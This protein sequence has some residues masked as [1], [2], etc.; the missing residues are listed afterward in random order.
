[1][2][3]SPDAPVFQIYA[4]AANAAFVDK[5][6][7]AL[8]LAGC[9]V[10]NGPFDPE[11][12][13]AVIVVWSGAAINSP[14]LIAAAEAP[15][16]AGALAPVS[17]G[18]IEPPEPFQAIPAVNLGGWTGDPDDPR[19]RRALEAARQVAARRRGLGP[20]PG[21]AA[22]VSVPHTDNSGALGEKLRRARAGA[23]R[24]AR[25]AGRAAAAAGGLAGRALA[26]GAGL[27]AGGLSRAFRALSGAR[28]PIA[29]GFAAARGRL[30]ALSGGTFGRLRGVSLD[31]LLRLLTSRPALTATG[32]A[33]FAIVA[34]GLLLAP[35]GAPDPG[36]RADAPRA[37]RPAPAPSTAP[38]ESGPPTLAHLQ[39]LD[40][41][42]AD[43]APKEAP[44]AEGD[45]DPDAPAPGETPDRL[46]ALIADA[47][48]AAAQ[49]EAPA[50]PEDAAPE[51]AEPEPP[52]AAAS[53]EAFRD[54][55]VC[56]LMRVAPAG[57]FR[58]GSPPNEPARQASEGP[59]IDVAIARPFAIGVHEITF[60]QW[61]ACVAD[62]GCDRH[63][64]GD[65]GWGR[66]ERPV[67]NV[68]WDDAQ[69]YVRWLSEKTG[70]AYRLPSEAEWEY[71][72]RAGATTPF[73]TG[74][75][76]T[77][78]QANFNGEH[79]Y[80]GEPGLFRKQTVPVGRFAPNAFGLHDM[81]GNV[82]EWVADCWT[83][84]HAGAPTDG[85]AREGG[86]CARRVL[87]GGAWNTGAWRLRAGHRLPKPAAAREFDN[88][89]RVARDVGE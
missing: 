3:S 71:A 70:K 73:A 85:A 89:F 9:R 82:W 57:S 39:P 23:G 7:R 5:I 52:S 83:H 47:T 59:Q 30:G 49:E 56:P 4:H 81:H 46:A 84:S 10:A 62:G 77:P 2:D 36:R 15:R 19:W 43:E 54:C 74:M 58:M 40:A 17:I 63:A 50:G 75:A 28:A 88:G 41:P 69:A 37:E 20:A 72:A 31:P 86:D 18:R 1:M 44:P 35:N 26:R 64:P 66:G 11:A 13:D 21:Q 87:K 80:I 25:K 27:A 42:A 34:A 14:A 45:A 22:P 61:D 29:R 51:T 79:P 76:I 8:D 78:D 68:S 65:A 16:A 32:L 48:E 67:I 12:V 24:A 6:A 60:A 53:G 33:A 38:E 55:D